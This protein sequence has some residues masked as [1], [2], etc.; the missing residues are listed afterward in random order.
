M[1]N[2]DICIFFQVISWELYRNLLLALTCISF[3]T[4]ILLSDWIGCV[5]VVGCVLLTLVNVAG[6]M[7]FWGKN[8]IFILHYVLEAL[9][10]YRLQ[11]PYMYLPQ[12][13][14]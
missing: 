9:D 11:M 2:T 8:S 12:Y 14:I 5:Q 4:L 1:K 6:F 7:H 13:L 10:A 3:T